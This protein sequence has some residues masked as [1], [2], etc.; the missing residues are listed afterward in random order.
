METKKFFEQKWVFWL[1]LVLLPPLAFWLIMCKDYGF[2]KN[3]TKALKIGTGIWLALWVL[4]ARSGGFTNSV[5]ISSADEIKQPTV[6]EQNVVPDTQVQE[7][8]TTQAEVNN[9]EKVVNTG[10]EKALA[11]CKIIWKA[12]KDVEDAINDLDDYVVNTDPNSYNYALIVNKAQNIMDIADNSNKIISDV[13]YKG[14]DNVK[15]ASTAYINDYKMY[16]QYFEYGVMYNKPNM[17]DTAKYYKS[18]ANTQVL[19]F[20]T[21]V[22]SF[23]GDNG[24]DSSD[25]LTELME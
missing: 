22:Y 19:T 25:G 14:I 1:A 11:Q 8:A 12:V 7:I 17:F 3:Q 24:F 5:P 9:T 6:A 23:L 13:K 15:K 2:T 10:N 20:V 21:N 16:A 4:S 18:D